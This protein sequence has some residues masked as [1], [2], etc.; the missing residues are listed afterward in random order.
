MA[1]ECRM[2][3]KLYGFGVMV[4]EELVVLGL[5]LSVSAGDL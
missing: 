1:R 2:G 3:V 5:G 4:S